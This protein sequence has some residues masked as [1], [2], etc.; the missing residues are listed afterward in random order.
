MANKKQSAQQRK[1][2]MRNKARQ[3]KEAQLKLKKELEVQPKKDQHEELTETATANNTDFM[4]RDSTGK[5]DAVVALAAQSPAVHMMV[6]NKCPVSKTTA[7]EFMFVYP[8]FA[9]FKTYLPCVYMLMEGTIETLFLY[10][11]NGHTL[12][13]SISPV[14]IMCKSC[15]VDEKKTLRKKNPDR[16][17]AVEMCDGHVNEY[18]TKQGYSLPTR[19]DRSSPKDY[20]TTSHMPNM[21]AVG[22]TKENSNLVSQAQLK[23]HHDGIDMN[24][25]APPAPPAEKTE[26]DGVEWRMFA[27]AQCVF[28]FNSIF[29]SLLKRRFKNVSI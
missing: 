19:R 21:G 18:L 26:Y 20:K 17:F 9:P 2:E 29:V 13:Y 10:D 28:L 3:V 4:I 27:W 5:V 23:H 6:S 8:G 15:D 24:F 12:P 25:T 7:G 14:C 1:I 22:L 11:G 16:L